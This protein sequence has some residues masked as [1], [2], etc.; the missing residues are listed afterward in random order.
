L[1]VQLG[2]TGVRLGL[3][4]VDPLDKR[5]LGVGCVRPRLSRALACQSFPFFRAAFAFVRARS[6]RVLVHA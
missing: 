2:R 3:A 4:T 1:P 5:I 6:H